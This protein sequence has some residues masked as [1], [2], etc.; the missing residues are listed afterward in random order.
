MIS[1]NCST[2]LG[3]GKTISSGTPIW[4]KTAPIF[5]VMIVL[6]A[7]RGLITRSLAK[8]IPEDGFVLSAEASTIPYRDLSAFEKLSGRTDWGVAEGKES[9]VWRREGRAPLASESAAVEARGPWEELV[10][11]GGTMPPAPGPSRTQTRVLLHAVLGK[12]LLPELRKSL[13]RGVLIG[14]GDRIWVVQSATQFFALAVKC[15][16]VQHD[17]L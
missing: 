3:V 17:A 15:G 4:V 12:Q 9:R 11:S 13:A 8:D 7:V 6:L 1:S 2:T 16:L 5:S 10:C 14:I